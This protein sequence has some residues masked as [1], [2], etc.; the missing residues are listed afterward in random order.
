MSPNWRFRPQQQAL[1][2][3]PSHYLPAAT[4]S[5]FAMPT[6]HHL[7]TSQ[8]SRADYIPRRSSLTSSSYA[9][10]SEGN[11]FRMV[12][13]VSPLISRLSRLWCLY[14]WELINRTGDAEP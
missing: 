9:A 2:T 11:G 13:V 10:R 12:I 1:L 3:S 14:V 7:A 8:A 5:S 6:Q 4:W